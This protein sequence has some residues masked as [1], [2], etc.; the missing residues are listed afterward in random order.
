MT[1]QKWRRQKSEDVPPT[2]AEEDRIKEPEAGEVGGRDRFASDKTKDK[3]G[4]Q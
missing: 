1:S 4:R 2:E 3:A